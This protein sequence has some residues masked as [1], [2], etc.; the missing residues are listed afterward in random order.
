MNNPVISRALAF[1]FAL[2]IQTAVQAQGPLT[3]PGPPAAL[4]KTLDQ[5]EPRTDVLRLPGSATIAHIIDRPGSYY[6]TGN[7]APT[8]QHG[9]RIIADD[10]T[11]DLNGFVLI[12][13]TNRT[14]IAGG[15]GLERVRIRNGVLSGWN[16]G[17]DFYIG[18]RCTNI[19]IEDLAMVLAPGTSVGIFSGP[20]TRVSRC[21]VAGVTG[22]SGYAI[23]VGDHSVV[24]SCEVVNSLGGINVGSQSAV[25][26]CAI[27][28]CPDNYAIFADDS[29]MVQHNRV[30]RSADGI[31]VND[32][33]LVLENICTRVSSGHGIY[34]SGSHSRIDGNVV[35]FNSGNGIQSVSTSS[36]NVVVR[37]MARG[38]TN[39]NYN[40]LG[41]VARGPTVTTTGIITNHP[42]ANFSY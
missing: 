42:W 6:L 39:G 20:G 36:N 10:V 33:C 40:F 15:S 34:L 7:L 13:P 41:S 3:P 2:S 29:S 25:R 9:I 11:L 1:T 32:H 18:G 16:G 38:N 37:N 35:S 19:V 12:G 30:D 28:D 27:T 22:G 4:L 8:N 31:R 5:L 17:I 24:E 14:A 21:R 26:D 23:V